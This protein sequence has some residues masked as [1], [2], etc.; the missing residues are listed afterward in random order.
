MS[1]PTTI[2][3]ILAWARKPRRCWKMRK[4]SRIGWADLLR[5][6]PIREACANSWLTRKA[7]FHFGDTGSNP[8]DDANPSSGSFHPVPPLNSSPISNFPLTGLQY[9]TV[10]R[11]Q[12]P[13]TRS[14]QNRHARS[15]TL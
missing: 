6:S 14:L 8:P 5:A 12:I 7:P 3:P 10:P 4:I 2:R 9:R 13:S 1:E 15:G 11:P